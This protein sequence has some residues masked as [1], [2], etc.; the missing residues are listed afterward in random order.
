MHDTCIDCGHGCLV[1]P[2]GG[3]LQN[4]CGPSP[5]EVPPRQ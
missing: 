2:A 5:E 3:L 1:A 4:V